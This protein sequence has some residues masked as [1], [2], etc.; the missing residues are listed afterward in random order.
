MRELK[1]RAWFPKEHY[2]EPHMAY[3]DINDDFGGKS[4]T[5]QLRNLQHPKPDGPIYMQ[6]TGQ[7]DKSFNRIEIYEG[8]LFGKSDSDGV[9]VF[10]EVYFDTD[11]AGFCVKYP[12]GGWTTLGEHLLEKQNHREII[13]NIY[14]NPELLK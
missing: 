3:L 5:W 9:E 14:E 7:K 4:A 10:G 6:Y 8:D 2:S 1:F 12:N 11:F 13:G